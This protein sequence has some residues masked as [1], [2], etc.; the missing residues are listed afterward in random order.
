MRFSLVYIIILNWN[1]TN[2]TI[3]CLKSLY[4][5]DYPRFQ[6]IV[7]DNGST[8]NSVELLRERYPQIVLIEN[9]SNLGF[10]GGNN[11]GIRYAMAHDA[12]Y[13]WL[14]NNDTVV[15][16]DSLSKLVDTGEKSPDIALISPVIYYYDDPG[17]VQFAGSY[18]NRSDLTFVYPDLPKGE[19]PLKFQ[20]GKDVI[21][22]GTALLVRRECIENIGFLKEDYFAYW[23]DMEYSLRSLK[24]GY[25]NRVCST[26]KVFH[27]NP[28][29][30]VIE[31]ARAKYHAYFLVRNEYFLCKEY[32]KGAQRFRYR[33]KLISCLINYVSFYHEINNKDYWEACLTGA[34]HG[35]LSISGPMRESAKAPGWMKTLFNVLSCWHP[36][37]VSLVIR[38]DFKTLTNEM[39]Q[40]FKGWVTEK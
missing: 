7:V 31:F 32:L 15:G 10:T 24:F 11:I 17:R 2:D 19:I 12:D 22:W 40:R 36:H 14:L 23:E 35:L 30:E 6:I 38:G 39:L 27:K 8:D 3:E 20:S 37:A 33:R 21:L 16:P 4:M 13:I 25:K 5:L 9:G 28:V 34:W 1:G 18:V 26:A 29:T